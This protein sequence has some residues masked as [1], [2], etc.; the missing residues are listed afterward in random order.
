MDPETDTF[1]SRDPL[2]AGPGWLGQP[3]GYASANPV[4]L[5]DPLGLFGWGDVLDFAQAGVDHILDVAATGAY[6]IYYA[7][8]QYLEFIDAISQQAGPLEV[9]VD[10]G[11]LPA[12]APLVVIQ[13]L[14]LGGDVTIDKLKDW[15]GTG[16]GW[17]D[18]GY[19]GS[20]CPDAFDELMRKLLGITCPKVYL[21]GVHGTRYLDE[22]GKTQVDTHGASGVDLNW[23]F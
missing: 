9:L 15:N 19:R 4:T 20:V 17:A 5:V 8:Y 7:A 2:A 21:P 16:Q 13:L 23:G 10:L 14:G 12:T 6:G 1:L 22:D 3:F 18:E 11:L